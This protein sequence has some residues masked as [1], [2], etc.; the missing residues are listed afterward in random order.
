[1]TNGTGKTTTRKKAQNG[2]WTRWSQGLERG[3]AR[4]LEAQAPWL[5]V[6]VL[7]ATWALVPHSG[8]GVFDGESLGE[9]AIAPR[10]F[11]APVDLPLEDLATTEEKRRKAREDVLP[12]YDFDSGL[13]AELDQRFQRLFARGR[14]LLAETPP[15]RQGSDP[16]RERVVAELEGFA[17][18][19]VDPAALALLYRDSF[20]MDLEDRIRGVLAEV[21]RLGVVSSKN[22]LL[23]NRVRGVT[24]LDLRTGTERRHLDLY[25]HLGYPDEVRDFVA[26]EVRRWPALNNQ[27]R[28]VV[29]DLITAN[30]SPNLNPNSAETLAR[31]D[32]AAAAA[33]P[34]FVQIR[35]GQVIVRKGDQIDAAAA[36]TIQTLTRQNRSSGNLLPLLGSFLLAL[37]AASVLWLGLRDESPAGQ[38]RVRLFNE[39]LL[40]LIAGILGAS[41]GFQLARSLSATIEADPLNSMNSYL[42]AVPF[43]SL[44]VVSRLLG[45]R[46]TALWVTLVFS[47]LTAGIAPDGSRWLG[48]FCLAGS[49]TAI[50]TLDRFQFKQRLVMVRAGVI[51]GLANAVFILVAA[52]LSNADELSLSRLGFDL[53]CGLLGGLIVGG[54][55]SFAV[56]ILESLL[57]LTTDIKL[58]ELSNTNLPLLRRLAFEAPGSFQHSLMV[59]NLAKAGC[60]AINADAV[61]AYTGA[62]YHDI[63]KVERSEYFIENQ[64]GGRNP[65]DKLSP[66]MSTLV[67]VNHVKFGLELARSYNLPPPLRDAIAQHHGTRRIT[68][69]YNKAKEKAHCEDEV[70]E[71]DFRYPGPKPQTKVMGVLMLADGVEAASRTLV[72]PTEQKIREL[73]RKIVE[74]CLKDGQLDETDLTL[75][76]IRMVSQAFHRVLSNIYHRRIDY[77]GFDFNQKDG[78]TA[79]LTAAE[80]A[81][82]QEAKAS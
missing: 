67:L 62:L 73:I 44:A 70:R 19:K 64:R 47:V 3:R 5:L 10:D 39:C 79:R 18:L 63:G 34:V 21:L 6:F 81:Q 58:V 26:A 20:S 1:M 43:A 11:V 52:A 2:F 48:L 78:K 17:G 9:G 68:F 56:P 69:F 49:L 53:A 14:E 36:R 4:L 32:A 22:L 74:D 16:L 76:D 41:F 50:F 54:V 23:D 7:L 51:I 61:L 72:E 66:S 15:E 12:V 55:A 82:V 8:L 30:I 57:S 33:E 38:S 71:A 46:N 60:E 40:F 45:S 25:D 28:Q 31:R 59:A 29:V 42:F 27:Q 75:A 35:R 13:A 24:L 37:L 65:H 77:P 80:E